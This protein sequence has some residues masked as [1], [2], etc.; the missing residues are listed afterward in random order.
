MGRRSE[1]QRC[2]S[3]LLQ[4]V[5][6]APRGNIVVLHR[7]HSHIL[8]KRMGRRTPLLHERVKVPMNNAIADRYQM[9]FVWQGS[10]A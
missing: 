6:C 10:A 9:G 3:L 4:L 1:W 8:N 5:A 7:G 2:S